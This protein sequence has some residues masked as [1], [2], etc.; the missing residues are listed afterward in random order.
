MDE[1]NLKDVPQS[2]IAVID[3]TALAP[4]QTWKHGKQAIKTLWGE[5]AWQL[6]GQEAYG[7]VKEVDMNGTSPGKDV[8]KTL[9]EQYAPCV[10]LIDELVAYIRQFGDSRTLSGGTYDTN[11]SFVQALTEGIK[12]VPNA[13]LLASLPESEVEA[14][15]QKGVVALKALEKTFGRVQALWKPVATEEAFEIIRRR[16]FEP[17]RDTKAR[18]GVCRAF[19]EAYLAEGAKM[20]SETQ[21]SRYYDRLV[22]AY[23]IHPEVFDRL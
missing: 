22:Q 2:R 17:I 1:A 6:G 7:L 13:I 4:G 12:L 15:S 3:G 9:L 18:D 20:P 14:G 21:E 10:I 19:A 11:L 16:L 23:H 8:L 5:L